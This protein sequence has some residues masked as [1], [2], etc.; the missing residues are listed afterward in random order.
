MYTSLQ[1]WRELVIQ[2]GNSPHDKH[3]VN[4]VYLK[5]IRCSAA[6]IWANPK[7]LTPNPNSI[8][9]KQ[10]LNNNDESLRLYTQTGSN[11]T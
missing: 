4:A 2:Q 11:Y 5:H 6:A 10:K 3:T 8:S 1:L 9:I 7:S